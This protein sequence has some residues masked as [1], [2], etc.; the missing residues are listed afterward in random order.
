MV[1]GGK[2]ADLQRV[3]MLSSLGEFSISYD[4]S[5]NNFRLF[6][7]TNT[8]LQNKKAYLTYQ[9]GNW[10]LKLKLPTGSQLGE[11]GNPPP[12]PPAQKAQLSFFSQPPYGVHLSQSGGLLDFGLSLG[13]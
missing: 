13:D 12:L 4:L 10:L 5:A 8:Y 6:V 3:G 9:G 2:V 7:P 11:W 1:S